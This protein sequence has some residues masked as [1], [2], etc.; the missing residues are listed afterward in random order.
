ME[1]RKRRRPS[2]YDT[3]KNSF[4]A[5]STPESTAQNRRA[6]KGAIDENLSSVHFTAQDTRSVMGV[7]RAK[8]TRRQSRKKRRLL[9]PD[10]AFTG[11]L[12]VLLAL[13]LSIYGVRSRERITSIT[14]QGETTAT[15]DF[16]S[17]PDADLVSPLPTPV[18]TAA[19]TF[20]PEAEATS[21]P[22]ADGLISESEAIRIAQD[23][24]NAQCDTTIFTFDEYEIRAVLSSGDAP[25]Y[26]VSMESIY[27]NGCTF[28]VILSAETGEIYQYSSPMLATI[29]AYIDGDSP[30]VRAWFDKYGKHLFIWPQDVQ[31]EFSR[32]YEGG[33]LRAAREGEITPEEAIAAVSQPIMDKAPDLFTAFY[34]VLYSE[35]A[36]STGRAFYLVYCFADGE[37]STLSGSTPMTV[38]FDAVTGDILSIENNPLDLS[39]APSLR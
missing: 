29:P 7:V 36:S 30:E 8:Q 17:H 22:T 13:P 34:P 21:A 14:T 20:P 12:V 27:K 37:E 26:T 1:P 39:L 38:S 32:R 3:G 11:A 5:S 25:Q 15:P 35:R 33:T 18:P 16:T 2:D 24:F 6:I 23:C 31:A 4:S 10:L 28:T 9:R 19:P